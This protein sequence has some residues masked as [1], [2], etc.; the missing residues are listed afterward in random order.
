MKRKNFAGRK[1]IRR[2]K[3]LIAIGKNLI[4]HKIALEKIEDKDEKKLL[5]DKIKR[6]EIV[7]IHTL[8]NMAK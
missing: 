4:K 6:I 7:E 5:E 1:N 3:A 2:E 8:K